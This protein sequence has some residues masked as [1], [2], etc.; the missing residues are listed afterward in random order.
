[1]RLLCGRGQCRLLLAGLRPVAA[2]ADRV[3]ELTHSAPQRTPDLGKSLGTEQQQGDQKHEQQMGWV[4]ET[5]EH[6]SHLSGD[7][8]VEDGA[9]ELAESFTG[10]P[11]AGR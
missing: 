7:T 1:L 2:A 6:V 5:A 4:F 3:L 11:L 10:C 9:D 8:G